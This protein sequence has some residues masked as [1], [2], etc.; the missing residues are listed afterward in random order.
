[1]TANRDV[2]AY[3]AVFCCFLRFGENAFV[4][5]SGVQ[6]KRIFRKYIIVMIWRCLSR[7]GE[8]AMKRHSSEMCPYCKGQGY[9]QLLLG[10]TE[11]CPNCQGEGTH[12]DEETQPVTASRT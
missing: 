2:S 7:G 12:T 3:I 11:D 6:Y 10:G 8:T 4:W 5:Y 1:M 9:F